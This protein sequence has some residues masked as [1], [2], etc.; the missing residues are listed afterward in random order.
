M[1]ELSGED[2]VCKIDSIKTEMSCYEK[3]SNP[4]ILNLNEIFISENVTNL[5]VKIEN[6]IFKGIKK[7]S[8]GKFLD[9]IK[10]LWINNNQI[11]KLESNSFQALKNVKQIILISNG[12]EDIEINA[13]NG[14][15]SL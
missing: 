8:Y 14:L 4:K 9:N 7:S 15:I 2:C 6:K 11:Q 13:F 1:C 3:S 5:I 12:I 10:E